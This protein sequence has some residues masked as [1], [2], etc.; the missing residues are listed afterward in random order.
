MS[1][2]FRLS[3]FRERE[4]ERERE[5][6][7]S[8]VGEGEYVR[9]RS[10]SR[11]RDGGRKGGQEAE[12]RDVVLSR[13]KNRRQQPGLGSFASLS[14]GGLPATRSSKR[15]RREAGK[16]INGHRAG[17]SPRPPPTPTPPTPTPLKAGCCRRTNEAEPAQAA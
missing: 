15:A 6:R 17:F 11:S 3:R 2:S 8:R 10:R 1:L 4:R 16:G 14:G 12:K 13:R 7:A 5:R 9:V